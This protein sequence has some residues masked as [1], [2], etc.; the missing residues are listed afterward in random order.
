[1]ATNPQTPQA[2]SFP[3]PPPVGNFPFID[4]TSGALT[5][6][7]WEFLQKLWASIQGSGGIIDTSLLTT[8]TPGVVAAMIESLAGLPVFRLYG[9]LARAPTPG[10]ILFSIPMA[11][12]ECFPANMARNIGIMT[13]APTADASFP[14][15]V[16]TVQVG[17][18]NVAAGQTLATWTLADSYTAA[19]G[20]ILEFQAPNPG[21]SA[22]S[23]PRYLFLGERRIR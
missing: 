1:M 9:N 18:M 7:G 15:L 6:M 21:D 17:S 5:P 12:D 13:A 4:T 2:A 19:K 22:L 11:G 8:L 20:D 10:Q 23:G 3:I 14:I 16:N